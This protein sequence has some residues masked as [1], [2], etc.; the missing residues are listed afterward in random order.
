MLCRHKLISQFQDEFMGGSGEIFSHIRLLD[1]LTFCFCITVH[2][3]LL[4]RS[5]AA[6]YQMPRIQLLEIG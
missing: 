6:E 3:S 4:L 2:E 1:S 5:K